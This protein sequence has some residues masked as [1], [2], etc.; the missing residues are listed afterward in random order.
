MDTKSVVNEPVSM[1]GSL[2]TYAD[3]LRWEFED[4]LEILRGKI[5]RM[6]PGPNT[7]HQK[8]SIRLTSVLLDNFRG[9][10][11]CEVFVAPFDVRLIDPKKNSTKD[12]DV[13]TVCQPDLC[14]ICN[15]E[16]IDERGAIGAPDLIVEI[17][18]PCNTKKE[19]GIKFELYEENGVREYWMVDPTERVI[20]QYVLEGK[21]F[22]G[23]KPNIEEETIQSAFFPNL[24]FTVGEIFPKKP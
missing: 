22:I 6:S 5:Y 1:Y 13:I 2:Y 17:L 23:K 14:V 20:Y 3:Y 11:R 18:S 19:M 12:E 7:L 9:F 15:E 8:V 24:E 4:R 16:K 21:R 10:N